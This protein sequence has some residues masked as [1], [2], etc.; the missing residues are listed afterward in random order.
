MNGAHEL[1]F[2]ADDLPYLYKVANQASLSGQRHYLLTLRADLAV[3]VAGTA[4]GAVSS[5]PEKIARLNYALAAVLFVTGF[6]LTLVLLVKNFDRK[7]YGGRAAAESVKTLAWKYAVRAEPFEGAD[8]ALVDQQFI[9]A[10]ESVLRQR[11]TLSIED[12]TADTTRQQITPV[13]RVLRSQSVQAR[14]DVYSRD[15]IG[16]QRS[17]Y[18]DRA[19]FNAKNG[20]KFFVFVLLSQFLAVGYSVTLV[21]V[22]SIPFNATGVLAIAAASFLVWMQAKQYQELSQVYTLTAQ[23]LALAVES[24][25]HISTDDQLSRFVSDTENA[26]SREHTLWSARRD[27]LPRLS[28]I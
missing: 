14:R 17:W 11:D 23:E 26:I 20:R 4:L 12:E 24:G 18:Q 13:M 9:A 6:I 5:L 27:H 19:R 28:R 22:P 7:W 10:L 1:K 3:L 8:P 25:R 2:A 21:A 15:R 16:N